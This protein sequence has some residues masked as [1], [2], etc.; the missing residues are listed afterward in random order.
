MTADRPATE[1]THDWYVLD[2]ARDYCRDCQAIKDMRPTE[3]MYRMT[4]AARWVMSLDL[5]PH[6]PTKHTRSYWRKAAAR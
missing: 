4:D 1:H 2:A 6:K 5:A 3:P